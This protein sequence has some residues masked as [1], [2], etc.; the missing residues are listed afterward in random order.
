[1][2]TNDGIARMNEIAA[3]AADLSIAN[4]A[5]IIGVP[6]RD[7]W[8]NLSRDGLRLLCI[9]VA[10]EALALDAKDQVARH[11]AQITELLRTDARQSPGC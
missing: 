9:S 3:K 6:V 5:G 11:E 2:A 10:T 8:R 7:L 1:M 4:T